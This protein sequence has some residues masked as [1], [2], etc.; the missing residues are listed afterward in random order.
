MPVTGLLSARLLTSTCA[1]GRIL[2]IDVK[3]LAVAG[4]K[5]VL[6][7][8]DCPELFGPLVLDRPALAHEFVRY[9]GEPVALVVARDEPTAEK[10]VR[11]IEVAYERLPAVLTPPSL[12]P[13]ALRWCT[14]RQTD[15]S[16]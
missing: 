7:G 5:A 9:A 16:G 15:T 11:L 14:D 1:H 12:W 8:A 2:R 4:V 3:A 6:T 10:A 13:K